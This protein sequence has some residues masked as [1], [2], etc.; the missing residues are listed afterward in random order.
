[1]K[2][3]ILSHRKALVL[4]TIWE[5]SDYSDQDAVRKAKS[6]HNAASIRLMQKA[7][8]AGVDGFL[9]G[10][11]GCSLCRPCLRKL[12]KPCAHPDLQYSCLSAYCIFVRKLAE[13]CGLEY[14]CGPGLVAFFGMYV[15]E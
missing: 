15:F 1:M 2:N 3:R 5:I 6:A 14:D 9:A 7:R 8:A 4:Q 11:S 10:A 12:G 13:S